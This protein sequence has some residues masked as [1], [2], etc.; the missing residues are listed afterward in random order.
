MNLPPNFKRLVIIIA[1]SLMV[2]FF[3]KMLLSKAA[4]NLTAEAQKK[5]QAKTIK[6]NPAPPEALPAYDSAESQK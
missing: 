5:Q 4:K 1:I 2:I 3:S 6:P